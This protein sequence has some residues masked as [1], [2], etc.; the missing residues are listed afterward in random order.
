MS[1]IEQ[2]LSRVQQSAPTPVPADA[3]GVP[4][5][6]WALAPQEAPAQ[7]VMEA[8][9][10][11][12]APEVDIDDPW[13]VAPSPPT[14][15]AP[16]A[17]LPSEAQ[18]SAATAETVPALVPAEAEAQGL[19][20]GRL[21]QQKIVGGELPAQVVEEYRRLGALVHHLQVDRG[22]RVV[23]VTSAV[24]GE[25]KTLTASNLAVVLSA[26]YGRSVLLIDADLRRPA[27]HQVF[28]TVAMKGLGDILAGSE[29]PPLVQVTPRLTLMTAG[30]PNAD[31]LGGLTSD[32]MRQ[33]L[34][35]ARSTFDFVIIDTPPVGLMTDANLLAAMVDVALLVVRATATPYELVRR[36]T[37]AIGRH[38]IAGVVLNRAEEGLSEHRSGYYA[39]YYIESRSRR[40][41]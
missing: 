6:P 10:A 9:P 24:A 30:A 23:M 28:N 25:G 29:P 34:D 16:V 41:G 15:A 27:L 22:V 3:D 18:Q 14:E 31:P 33:L 35:E 19:R 38:R 26:S 37:E 2:A 39:D 11:E 36:A 32:R 8:G 40:Q 7:P 20:V 21:F 13:A 12:A 1:R 5:D 17:L 4:E